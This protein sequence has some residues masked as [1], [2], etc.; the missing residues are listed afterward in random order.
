M[1]ITGSV[2]SAVILVCIGLKLLKFFGLPTLRFQ[3]DEKIG[4]DPLVVKPINHR[5]HSNQQPGHYR[6]QRVHEHLGL[7]L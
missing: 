1:A 3:V 7:R 4:T 2:V 5:D 6:G